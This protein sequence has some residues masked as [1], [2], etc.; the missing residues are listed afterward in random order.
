LALFI[1]FLFGFVFFKKENK[2]PENRDDKRQSS[3]LDTS[4][5]GNTGVDKY[6][7]NQQDDLLQNQVTGV[8]RYLQGKKVLN[9]EK[10]ENIA[11]SGVAKYLSK[12][13]ETPVSGVSRY[14][15][16]QTIQAKKIAQENV[17][18]VEKYLNNRH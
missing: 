4:S 16:R 15:A 10:A 6:I 11:I 12:K 14:M 1:S 18:G 17:S 9:V 3:Y 2:V 5:S 7:Q 13:E 8:S